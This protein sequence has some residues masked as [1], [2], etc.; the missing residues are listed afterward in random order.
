[1]YY[2]LFYATIK[3]KL[4]GRAIAQKQTKFDSIQ[5]NTKSEKVKQPGELRWY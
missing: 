4:E 2:S 3:T 5:Q 1:M